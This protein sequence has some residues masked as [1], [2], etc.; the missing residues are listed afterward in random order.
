MSTSIFFSKKIFY[1]HASV[2]I[3]LTIVGPVYF[4]GGPMIM[5]ERNLSHAMRSAVQNE[6]M[7]F[8]WIIYIA[9]ISLLPFTFVLPKLKK[10]T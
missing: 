1:I 8:I 7:M 4:I 3:L 6:T 5:F 9:T 10:M 2:S